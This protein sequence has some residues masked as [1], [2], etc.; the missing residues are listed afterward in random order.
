[1]VTSRSTVASTVAGSIVGLVESG[2]SLR[3]VTS[4]RRT[5]TSGAAAV[6]RR[7]IGV[8]I[9]FQ[10]VRIHKPQWIIADFLPKNYVL[11]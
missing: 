6:K 8:Q 4:M 10:M 7:S 2:S 9:K 3:R 1:M 5:F 11:Y